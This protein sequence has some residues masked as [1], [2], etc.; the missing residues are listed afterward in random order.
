MDSKDSVKH[1]GFWLFVSMSEEDEHIILSRLKMTLVPVAS[2]RRTGRNLHIPEVLNP[3]KVSE[4]QQNLRCAHYIIASHL[5]CP[6][7]VRKMEP[8]WTVQ[9]AEQPFGRSMAHR[10]IT[11]RS[12]NNPHLI[13]TGWIQA[14]TRSWSALRAMNINFGSR[15]ELKW[16]HCWLSGIQ[17]HPSPPPQRYLVHLETGTTLNTH[18][19]NTPR[20]NGI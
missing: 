19:H 14:I 9:S 2:T 1:R 12:H 17:H 11:L 7:C 6:T 18:S 3:R 10:G 5:T 13:P 16:L 20:W 8:A 4:G 15:L